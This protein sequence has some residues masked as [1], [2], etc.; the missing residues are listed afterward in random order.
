MRYYL[1]AMRPH[2]WAKNLLVFLVVITGHYFDPHTLIVTTAAFVC[3]C[4]AASS[5]YILNDLIDIESDR[6]H[7][8]KCRR[9]I[10]AGAIPARRAMAFSA[11]LMGLALG[12]ATALPPAFAAV[13]AVYVAATVGY[14]L[15]LKR[16]AIL[17]VI[18]LGA[19][20]TIRVF[21]GLMASGAKQSPWLFMFC[22]FL[23]TSLALVKR[24]SELVMRRDAG[25]ASV[26]GRDYTVSDLAVLFP[27][28]VAAGFGAILIVALYM[29]S[30][31]VAELYRHP[32]RLWLLHPVL[33]YWI[34]RTILLSSRNQL[35]EDPVVFALT[36]RVSW[37][38]GVLAAII[39]GLAI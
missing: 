17:D 21:A 36:D 18:T 10:A 22:L 35:H 34:S 39:I 2:Q 32:S 19:L 38:V 27:A 31:E 23:F 25:E 16:I 1:K 30:P 26:A 20:Y 37:A 15:M 11:V 12:L 29:S 28:A 24:C 5:A 7:P 8:T 3:F 14:S 13:L 6:A 4:L 9:P 33:I